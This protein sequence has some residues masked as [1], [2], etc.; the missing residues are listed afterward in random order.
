MKLREVASAHIDAPPSVIADALTRA[1]P[2]TVRTLAPGRLEVALREEANEP[3]STYILEAVANGTR[4]V[5]G[6]TFVPDRLL[7]PFTLRRELAALK[8]SV[9]NDL[10]FLK[11][12][13]ETPPD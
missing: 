2:G 6:V 5:H 11:R 9:A 1:G 3:A 4:V 7:A 10:A 8:T 13:V 12:V